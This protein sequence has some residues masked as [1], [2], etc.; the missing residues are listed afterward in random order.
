M[1]VVAVAAVVV[2]GVGVG[3]VV[4]VVVVGFWLPLLLSVVVVVVVVLLLLLPP[5]LP[6]PL[7]SRYRYCCLFWVV[8]VVDVA[9]ATFRFPVEPGDVNNAR[10]HCGSRSIDRCRT[11]STPWSESFQ[12][13]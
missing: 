2:V 9:V 4:V 3:V 1:V 13:D 7:L 11:F 8:G 10:S 12:P 6:P 5:P